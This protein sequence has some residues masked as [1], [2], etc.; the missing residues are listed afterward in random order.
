MQTRPWGRCHDSGWA[1]SLPPGDLA[2]LLAVELGDWASVPRGRSGDATLGEQ[3]LDVAVRQ[4]EAQVPSDGQQAGNN[5]LL[6]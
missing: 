5:S 1:K 2:Q 4:A 6:A 3:L